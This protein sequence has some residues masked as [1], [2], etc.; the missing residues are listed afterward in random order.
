MSAQETVPGHAASTCVLMASMRSKPK[1]EPP[2]LAP[3]PFSPG[4]AGVSSSSTEASQPCAINVGL[5]TARGLARSERESNA[6]ARG[7]IVCLLT[8]TK[9]S[10]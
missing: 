5:I 9:Q 10:W 6:V 4:V 1:V 7:T 8:L 2:A 3:A